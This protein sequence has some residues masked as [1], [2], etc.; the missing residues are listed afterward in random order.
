MATP[1]IAGLA[2]YIA[3]VEGGF[4]SPDALCNR[5]KDLALEDVLT[6]IPSG[7][8]NLLANNGN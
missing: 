2:A 8:P 3:G 1:H 6:G 5:L 4:S 7:T